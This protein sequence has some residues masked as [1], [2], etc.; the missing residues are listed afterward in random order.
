LHVPDGHIGRR[1]R[2]LLQ[3]IADYVPDLPQA[4]NVQVVANDRDQQVELERRIELYLAI[5]LSRSKIVRMLSSRSHRVRT[6]PTVR[7]S[8]AC[9]TQ[10]MTS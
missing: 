2:V 3:P 6:E 10:S 9:A 1:D 7:I 8:C 4:L 5:A